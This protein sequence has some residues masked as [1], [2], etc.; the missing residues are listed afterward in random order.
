MILRP[1]FAA[2]AEVLA[3]I[4]A[5]AFAS[6]DCWGPAAIALML[7]AEGG[8]GTLALSGTPPFGD[9]PLG[10]ALG[11]AMADEAEVL[12]LAVRPRARRAGV[13]SALLAALR[14]AARD[15]GASVLYLEV[16]EG[17]AGALAL[18]SGQGG[19]EAGRRR[20]YYSDGSDAL[21]LRFNLSSG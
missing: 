12:T 10:F 9:E 7:E 2:E 14:A 18:Y 8:F 6:P 20:R 5:E 21:V 11:R 16:A 3:A 19:E 17:N 1:A 15:R 13:G 4:H